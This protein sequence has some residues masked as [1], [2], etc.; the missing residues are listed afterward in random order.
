MKFVKITLLAFLCLSLNVL[1]P[2]ED[3][4]KNIMPVDHNK[5]LTNEEKEEFDEKLEYLANSRHYTDK[6]ESFR[7]TRIN[8]YKARSKNLDND[9]KRYLINPD[10]MKKLSDDQIEN[11]QKRLKQ[12][13]QEEDESNWSSSKGLRDDLRALYTINK[14]YIDIKASLIE[15]INSLSENMKEIEKLKIK[16]PSLEAGLILDKS[17]ITKEI[18]TLTENNQKIK[19]TLN[20]DFLEIIKYKVTK[21]EYQ[22]FK[23][24]ITLSMKPLKPDNETKETNGITM[25]QKIDSLQKL[26][27]LAEKI[28]PQTLEIQTY[29]NILRY[30]LENYKHPLENEL[31]LKREQLKYLENTNPTFFEKLNY[32]HAATIKKMRVL[33]TQRPDLFIEK[34]INQ[35]LSSEIDTI[36]LLLSADQEK[37][38][39]LDKKNDSEAQILKQNIA[40]YSLKIEIYNLEK[41]VLTPLN[42]ELNNLQTKFEQEK[43]RIESDD[44]IKLKN[45]LLLI[46]Q[47]PIPTT[48]KALEKLL[49]EY[50]KE[51]L[52]LYIKNNAV[53][54]IKASKALIQL[55]ELKIK[56]NKFEV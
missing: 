10:E 24:L 55:L 54:F 29:I 9:I 27:D 42:D 8:H 16:L 40:W 28:T 52:P 41:K 26:I 48:S 53:E 18:K 45:S 12:R 17:D 32:N 39:K 56:I 43:R 14:R 49:N 35:V 2:D 50:K 44:K 34:L 23:D 5:E 22:K 19:I 37:L 47:T 1:A 20:E 21:D 31:D 33:E 3:N 51:Y 7:N 36:K 6:N 46:Y 11:L 25:E 13:I 4:I 38:Q 15:K 30:E